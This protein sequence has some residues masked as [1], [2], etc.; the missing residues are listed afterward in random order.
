MSMIV[1]APKSTCQELDNLFCG[2]I[3][4][5]STEDWIKSTRELIVDDE[6]SG[7]NK[8]IAGQVAG[9]VISG[10]IERTSILNEAL[11]LAKKIGILVWEVD[12]FDDPEIILCVIKHAVTS[13]SVARQFIAK[14]RS[15]E[16]ALRREV[17]RLQQNFQELENFV[18]ELGVPRFMRTLDI[19]PT[20]KQIVLHIGDIKNNKLEKRSN[21][22]YIKDYFTQLLPISGRSLVA[23]D[24]YCVDLP[25]VVDAEL[26][27]AVDDLSGQ[28]LCD[29]I[30]VPLDQFTSEW[31]RIAFP[32]AIDISHRDA[33]L[34]LSLRSDGRPASLALALGPAVPIP[35]FRIATE[36]GAAAEAPLAL[37]AWRGLAGVRLPPL[38]GAMPFVGSPTILRA[39]QVP[40]PRLLRTDRSKADSDSVEYL[41]REDAIRVLPPGNGLTLGIIERV[42]VTNLVAVSALVNVGHAESAPLRF[43]VGI[44]PSGL[45]DKFNV[46]NVLGP[47]LVLRP[48]DW[49]EVH[50][51]LKEPLTGYCDL[52]LATMV[53]VGTSN[54][55]GWAFFRSFRLYSE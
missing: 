8:E 21:I 26:C 32:V 45:A 49:G 24:I 43:A 17:E 50:T 42:P 52:V 27:L 35:R 30:T 6:V 7:D 14:T 3:D 40:R 29:V 48:L 20:N 54:R 33:Q 55:K 44:V 4:V 18:Q 10:D 53:A 9:M 46:E 5:R 2:I 36:N 34:T 12:K 47:W 38:A 37:R 13:A 31:N 15:S 51:Y 28:A 25:N 41:E 19:T 22:T 23:I 16:A 1:L 11:A 39:G